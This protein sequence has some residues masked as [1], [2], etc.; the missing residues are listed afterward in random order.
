MKRTL[1]A[2]VAAFALLGAAPAP[3]YPPVPKNGQTA[4]VNAYLHDLQSGAYA[5]AFALLNDQARGYYRNAANFRSIYDADGYRVQKYTLLGAR[6]DANGRVYFARETASFH[7]HARNADNTVTATLPIGV[8]A[9]KGG[10]RIKDPGHPWRAFA[11][12]A[13]VKAS[14]LTVSVKKVSFFA[15]RIEV[16]A[17]FANTGDGFVTVLPYRRSVLR[18][19]LGGVYRVIETKDWGL[20]DKT[21]F[22]GLRLAPSGQY[23][24]VLNFESTRIDDR[25]RAFT[26][27]IAPALREGADA[28]FTIDVPNLQPAKG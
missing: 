8:I 19:D 3:K 26:L 25:A 4:V 22:L 5:D 11:S 9:V 15:D 18:D 16:V 27:T 20:T 12:T 13:S 14:D 23:T 6:G 17:T 2:Y 21:L 7:D 10:W 24:G 28:P 1:V